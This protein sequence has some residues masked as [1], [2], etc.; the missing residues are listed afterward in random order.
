MNANRDRLTN[1]PIRRNLGLF[2]ALSFLIA[3]LMAIA[4]AVGLLYPTIIYPAEELSRAFVPN[5][6]VNLVVGLPI[7]LVSLGLALRGKLVGLLCWPGA[8]LFVIYTYTGYT[9]A[10]P[11]SWAFPLYLVLAV[12]SV[13]TLV[14]LVASIDGKA[15]QQRLTGAVPEKVTGG[16]LAGL[17]LLFLLRVMGVIVG[18][19]INETV[20]ADADLG[21]NIA[22]FFVAPSLVIGGILLW[23][24]KEL[25]YV[26]GLGLLFQTSMLFIGLIGF[27]LLQPLL[28]TEPFAITDVIV[29]FVMGLVCFIPFVLFVRGV[30]AKRHS[31]ST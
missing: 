23:Q 1:L 20:I 9:F 2:F 28:T 25:G 12:A 11:L 10:L 17:G 24:R 4:S 13:Y 8:L 15:V 27:M 6:I 5:D 14:G 3:L 26:T 7:L 21:V 22:D 30:V 16:I 29:V 19:L 31:P 18:A